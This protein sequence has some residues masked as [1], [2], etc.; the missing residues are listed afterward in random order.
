MY[1][2]LYVQSGPVLRLLQSLLM[3]LSRAAAEH[4][5]GAA[6]SGQYPILPVTFMLLYPV[7]RGILMLPHTMPGTEHTFH[8][9][10]RSVFFLNEHCLFDRGDHWFFTLVYHCYTFVL[11][12]ELNLNFFASLWPSAEVFTTKPGSPL[13][14]SGIAAVRSA[15]KSVLVSFSSFF[16]Y[17][18]S[19]SMLLPSLSFIQYLNSIDAYFLFYFL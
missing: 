11:F 9:L 18:L 1:R 10:D 3:V 2:K 15:Q 5:S 7:L 16:T 14:V 8:L 6:S 17:F 19:L 13:F 12:Y 4:R